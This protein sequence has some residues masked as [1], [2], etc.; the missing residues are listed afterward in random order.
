MAAPR[1]WIKTVGLALI[2]MAAI[3]TALLL[4]FWAAFPY[5]YAEPGAAAYARA[6]R[7]EGAAEVF[8]AGVLFIVAWICIRRVFSREDHSHQ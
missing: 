7:R 3:A 6:Q 5:I 2:A 8:S 1:S 4:L